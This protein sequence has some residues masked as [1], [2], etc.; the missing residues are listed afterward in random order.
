MIPNKACGGPWLRISGPNRPC[1]I[2]VLIICHCQAS[3]ID[4][5]GFCL[6]SPAQSDG[7]ITT[8]VWDPCYVDMFSLR[9]VWLLALSTAFSY[10]V[11][12]SSIIKA[13]ELGRVEEVRAQLSTG[14][15]SIDYTFNYGQTLL[16][17]AAAYPNG[18]MIELLLGYGAKLDALDASNLT[19]L[20]IAAM[21]NQLGVLQLMHDNLGHDAFLVKVHDVT[22][23]NGVTPLHA[24]AAMG[25]ADAV[26]YL[27]ENGAA[28]DQQDIKGNTALSL[29]VQRNGA[30]ALVPLLERN[31]NTEVA[32]LQ[33][34]TPLYYAALRGHYYNAMVLLQYGASVKS[35]DIFSLTP[36]HIAAYN[37]HFELAQLLLNHGADINA[38]NVLH[39]T[40][41]YLASEASHFIIVRLLVVRG[42]DV[43]I[44]A[45][46][47]ITAI[48]AADG[49][50]R[51]HIIEVLSNRSTAV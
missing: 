39:Q 24:A 18:A 23:V 33:G 44:R 29:A 41:L 1:L 32:N 21:Y 16:H 51:E 46:S 34:Y 30:D 6:P 45:N 8:P 14:T 13:V 26:V 7:N 31:A 36:L 35:A 17:L 43:D 22:N 27:L 4:W 3:R 42:A 11:S 28:I 40:P 38:V 10:S 48:Q 25:A 47:G 12:A 5:P 50:D 9:A 2:A 19:P 37:G 20:H 15:V 49:Q